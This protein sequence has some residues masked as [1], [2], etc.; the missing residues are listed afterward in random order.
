MTI[1]EQQLVDLLN[2]AWA[3]LDEYP[4]YEE[5]NRVFPAVTH[6]RTLIDLEA[7]N[8]KLGIAGNNTNIRMT[9][10]SLIATITDVLCDRR[11]AAICEGDA[12]DTPEKAAKRKITGWTFAVYPEEEKKD[13]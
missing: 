13:V 5:F 9:T 11:L 8:P 2:T 3:T 7:S 6:S 12:T 4:T 10:L 1:K